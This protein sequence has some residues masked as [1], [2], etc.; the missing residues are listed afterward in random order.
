MKCCR[1]SCRCSQ[2]LTKILFEVYQTVTRTNK[3]N[4]NHEQCGEESRSWR[5]GMK[6][7]NGSASEQDQE[8][9]TMWRRIGI[10]NNQELLR[11][12]PSSCRQ[13]ESERERENGA[14]GITSGGTAYL[15]IPG[16]SR[17]GSGRFVSHRG[18][19]YGLITVLQKA[20]IHAGPYVWNWRN[21]AKK[22]RDLRAK[23][24]RATCQSAES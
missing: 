17:G 23:V 16:T 11:N 1:N 7:K 20:H 21:T 9:E 14:S 5:I 22:F 3:F 18:L 10:K 2:R 8:Q 19:E 4:K 13:R 12:S 15:T 24:Q 6:N